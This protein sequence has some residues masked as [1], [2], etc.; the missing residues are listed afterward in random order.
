MEF[1]GHLRFLVQPLLS[2]STIFNTNNKPGNSNN[3]GQRLQSKWH[4][5]LP[6]GEGQMNEYTIGTEQVPVVADFD[7]EAERGLYK[8]DKFNS[9]RQLGGIHIK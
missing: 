2:N 1:E 5:A 4:T 9:N 3:R 6:A 7:A 8:G